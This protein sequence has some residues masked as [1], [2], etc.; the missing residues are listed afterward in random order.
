MNKN[1]AAVIA[2]TVNNPELAVLLGVKPG[3]RVDVKCKNGVP[4]TREWRNRF[5]DSEVDGCITVRQNTKKPAKSTEES[6]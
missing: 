1:A 3:A 2:V 5:K 6:K 4:V